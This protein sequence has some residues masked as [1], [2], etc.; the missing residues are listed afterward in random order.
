MSIIVAACLLCAVP[1]AAV[2]DT[3][4]L[5]SQQTRQELAQAIDS[6][7]DAHQDN[8]AAVATTIF[9]GDEDIYTRYYGYLDADKRVALDE[10]CVLEWGSTTKLTVWIS[11]MQLQEAGL[12]DLNADIRTY[13]P[14]DFLR[15]LRYDEPITML[16]LM[17]HNAGFQETDFV[18]EATNESEIIAL[19]DYL[20]CYQP[21]QVF[22][23]GEVVAYS[24][25]GAALAGYVV[26]CIAEQ[27][28]YAYVQ[29]HIFAPLGMDQSALAADLSDNEWVRQKRK[30]YV[31]YYPDGTLAEDTK[32]Y[33]LPYPAGMCVSSLRDFALFAKALLQHD[34]R[35][36]REE[37]YALMFSPSLYYTDTQNAR[38]DHG[39]LVDYDFAVPIVGHDGN[40]AGG[41]SRLFLDFENNIG[42]V[43]LT[44]QLGGSVYR[45]A[46]AELVFGTSQYH[47]EVDGYYLPARTVHSGKQKILYN[48]FFVDHCHITTQLVDGMYINVLPDRLEISATDYLAETDQRA[49]DALAVVWFVMLA[50]AFGNLIA[51]IVLLV[52]DAKK[53]T[54]DPVN[55]ASA[56]FSL[57]LTLAAICVLPSLSQT[58]ALVFCVLLCLM[59][60]ALV[61]VLLKYRKTTP[62][63]RKA[64]YWQTWSLL[65][66]L[67]ITMAN[68]FVWDLVA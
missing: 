36:M 65:A 30:D 11:A 58:F 8:N 1:Q 24:N 63:K 34:Q 50:Y 4:L 37:T 39:F 48:L 17:N 59:G 68:F 19:G 21:T 43:M 7:L 47:I 16:H 27:P 18:L 13:L 40:T 38:I 64:A 56:I 12:L 57:F 44:N 60:V 22:K 32:V 46:M 51:R 2:A 25:W 66:C 49:L 52:A 28:F 61:V 15:N 42:M 67:A 41:S 31:S 20:R 23:P 9:C 35:L 62:A 6:F 14:K 10:T 3:D 55:L 45:N 53:K 54:S 26:E 5:P 33:I 29:Q